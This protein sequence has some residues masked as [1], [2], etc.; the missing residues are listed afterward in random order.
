MAERKIGARK[1]SA[2]VIAALKE[3][4]GGVKSELEDLKRMMLESNR[5]IALLVV[6]IQT[7]NRPAPSSSADERESPHAV[8]ETKASG[9]AE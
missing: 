1:T 4:M 2:D 8:E 3:Q 7:N 5:L 6:E 9:G